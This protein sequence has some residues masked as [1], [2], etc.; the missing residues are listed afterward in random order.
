MVHSKCVG[1]MLRLR[2]DAGPN[3]TDLAEIVGFRSVAPVGEPLAS[4]RHQQIVV[5][6]ADFLGRREAAEI[7]ADEGELLPGVQTVALPLPRTEL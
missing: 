3:D 1:C 4:D 2:T 5:R 6:L 7:G